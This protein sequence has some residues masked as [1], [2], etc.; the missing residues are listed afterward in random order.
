[1]AEY[2]ERKEVLE[3]INNWKRE[4][5]MPHCVGYSEG[6]NEALE[7]IESNV[8]SDI[9]A[10]DVRPQRHGRWSDKM[11]AVSQSSKAG[12]HEDDFAFG[13]QCLECG[14]VLN[15]TRYCGSCGAKMD[16]KGV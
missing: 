16:G 13:F 10:A 12:Y 3:L 7:Q 14:D 9:P 2:I 8:K 15:K 1:M 6:W 4:D 11:V 5:A